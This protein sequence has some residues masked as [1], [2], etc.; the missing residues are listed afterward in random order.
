MLAWDK[1]NIQ[2]DIQQDSQSNFTLL[3]RSINVEDLK[4]LAEYVNEV[5][6]ARDLG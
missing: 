2:Q 4:D 1:N 6:T 3:F 5:T